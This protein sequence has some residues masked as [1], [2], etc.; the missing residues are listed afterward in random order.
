MPAARFG[1]KMVGEAGFDAGGFVA[2]GE[3]G[4]F[5]GEDF[6]QVGQV[7]GAL[8]FD[9]DECL[10]GFLGFDGAYRLIVDEEEVVGGAGG[11][12]EFANG[13]ALGRAEVHAVKVLYEPASLFE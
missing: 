6:G 3:H 4:A 7:F 11:E 9:A 10:S 1:V 2:E 5:C 13:D 12:G 8:F